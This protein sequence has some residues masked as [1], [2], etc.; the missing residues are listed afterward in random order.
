MTCHSNEA[1]QLI[2]HIIASGT[3]LLAIFFILL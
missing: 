3:T 2:S 1:E